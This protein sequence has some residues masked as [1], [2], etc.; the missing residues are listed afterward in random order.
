MG[1]SYVC[2]KICL[3]QQLL[4]LG[5]NPPRQGALSGSCRPMLKGVAADG[6]HCNFQ[7][8]QIVA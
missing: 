3:L 2:I 8:Y 6:G 1:F 4:E 5:G 7:G